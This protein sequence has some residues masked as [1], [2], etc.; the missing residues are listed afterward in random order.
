MPDSTRNPD[1]SSQ[2]GA[3]K[4][5][6]TLIAAALLL[7]ALSL[8]VIYTARGAFFSPLALMVVAAIGLAAL[9]LQIQLRPDLSSSTT[10]RGPLWLNVM[11]VLSALAALGADFLRARQ[12]WILIAALVAVVSF[13]ISGVIVLS[14][15]RKRRT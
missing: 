8:V 9:L 14:G 7:A 1:P 4:T 11:G 15:L 10:T 6:S 5:R 13:G 12:V 2:K 3:Q